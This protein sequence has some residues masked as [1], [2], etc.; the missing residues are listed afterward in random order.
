MKKAFIYNASHPVVKKLLSS[1]K[2]K[3]EDPLTGNL[4]RS[5]TTK[6][7]YTLTHFKVFNNCEGFVDIGNAAKVIPYHDILGNIRYIMCF[8]LES[9]GDIQ[10]N[11]NGQIQALSRSPLS[12]T[13]NKEGLNFSTDLQEFVD[14]EQQVVNGLQSIEAAHFEVNTAN[15]FKPGEKARN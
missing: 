8:S 12:I 3:V 13:V 10:V 11:W 14:F 5:L 6:I 15:V 4:L 1:K 9:T 7:F 2:F